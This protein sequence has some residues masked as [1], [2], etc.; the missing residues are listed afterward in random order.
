MAPKTAG[1][2]GGAV[3]TKPAKKR[4]TP[5]PVPEKAPVDLAIGGAS[6]ARVNFL[7]DVAAASGVDVVVVQKTLDALHVVV[8]RQIREKTCCRI[9]NMVQLRLKIVPAREACTRSAFGKEVEMKARGA[10]KKV[11]VS[12]LKPLKQ[13]IVE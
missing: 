4:K 12:V 11:L 10:I 13:A 2:K 6:A 5:D 7:Q 3:S 8:G 1:I 9:P